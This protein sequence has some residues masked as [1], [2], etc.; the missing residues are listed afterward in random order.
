MATL[1]ITGGSLTIEA[2]DASSPV[3]SVEGGA[4]SAAPGSMTRTGA[5]TIILLAD[6]NQ[7]VAIPAGM[8]IGDVIEGHGP[9]GWLPVPPAGET[10]LNGIGVFRTSVRKVATS[11][12]DII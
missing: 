5:L 6:Q 10:F 8:E 7:W 12:W 11:T 1:T 9:S 3:Q 2:P 4:T